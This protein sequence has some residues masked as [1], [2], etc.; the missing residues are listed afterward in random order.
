MQDLPEL[1]MPLGD[2][3]PLLQAAVD[4]AQSHRMAQCGTESILGAMI[5]GANRQLHKALT[6]MGVDV[7]HLARNVEDFF[8]DLPGRRTTQLKEIRLSPRAKL[9]LKL[10]AQL[11]NSQGEGSLNTVYLL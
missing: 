4:Y 6:D 5:A 8:V 2:V 11:A 7:E 3:E 1:G 9:A 10:A